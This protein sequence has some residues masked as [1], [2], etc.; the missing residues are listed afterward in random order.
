MGFAAPSKRPTEAG[1]RLLIYS[2]V[3]TVMTGIVLNALSDLGAALVGFAVVL[4]SAA[5]LIGFAGIVFIERAKGRVR[6]SS[7]TR[8]RAALFTAISAAAFLFASGLLLGVIY[9]PAADVWNAL[10][11][12]ARFI[13]VLT[14][15]LYLLWTAERIDPAFSRPLAEIALGFGVISAALAT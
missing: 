11:I 4:P 5:A 7:R 3:L 15:G 12:A 2:L 9:V 10:R 13:A 1:S 8:A 6:D 14:V